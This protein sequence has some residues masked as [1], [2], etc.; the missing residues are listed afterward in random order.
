MSSRTQATI[1]ILA[2]GLL[3]SVSRADDSA[4][5]R[6]SVRW[7][8]APVRFLEI[9]LSETSLVAP[10]S[11]WL[12]TVSPTQTLRRD[13]LSDPARNSLGGR[14]N[15]ENSVQ[16]LQMEVEYGVAS[17]LSLALSSSFS[18]R[19]SVQSSDGVATT[20]RSRGFTDP[21]MALKGYQPLAPNA[22][23]VYSVFGSFSPENARIAAR[24]FEGNQFSGRNSLGARVGFE[25]ELVGRTDRKSVV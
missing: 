3:A 19:E 16:R 14:M 24:S 8:A 11:Q 17:N 4:A 10:E 6:S 7:G 25:G 9:P 5:S 22:R 12:L 23:L 15:D 2:I 1:S 21:E 18:Q 13:E 20:F